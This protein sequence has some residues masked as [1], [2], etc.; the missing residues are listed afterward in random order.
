MADVGV[1]YCISPY[2]TE[3]SWRYGGFLPQSLGHRQFSS[4]VTDSTFL[5]GHRL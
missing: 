5:D 4:V 3:K 2:S 1:A